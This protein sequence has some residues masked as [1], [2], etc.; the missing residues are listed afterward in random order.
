MTGAQNTVRCTKV[1]EIALRVYIPDVS[2][3]TVTQR[4]EEDPYFHVVSATREEEAIG[5]AAGAYAVGRKAAVF[6]QS[7]GFGNC[8]NALAS[9]CIPYRIPLP[10]LINLRGQVDEFNVSQVVMGRSTQPI[11]D[12]LGLPHYTLDNPDTM[13][14]IVSGALKLCY[15]IR[16][17]LPLCMTPLLPG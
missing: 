10:L 4:M 6:M 9:L 14:R 17:P 1:S 3:Y 7:S 11:L 15:A 8:I 2:I 13:E 5:I 12:A 16:H